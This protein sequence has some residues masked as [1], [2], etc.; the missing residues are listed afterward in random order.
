MKDSLSLL[1]VGLQFQAWKFFSHYFFKHFLYSPLNFLFRDY[2]YTC[3]LYTYIIYSYMYILLLHFSVTQSC[4]TL[5]NPMDCSTPAFP[6]YHY[7]L[8]FAQTHVHWVNDNIQPS[9]PLLPLLFL[10]S[11][12]PSIRVFFQWVGSLHQV[13]KLTGASA[14]A[15]V[16]PMNIQG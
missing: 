3:A 8:E 5:C 16:L 11:I 10:P 13:A 14:S 2:I 6:V 4:L 7:L 15:S 9:P 12:F 1:C